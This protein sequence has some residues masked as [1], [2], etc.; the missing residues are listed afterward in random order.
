MLALPLD[1]IVIP[2]NGAFTLI[3]TVFE[4]CSF[5]FATTLIFAPCVAFSLTVKTF[6]LISAWAVPS[7]IS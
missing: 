5:A 4:V 2:F 1:E 3:S 7:I 6:P